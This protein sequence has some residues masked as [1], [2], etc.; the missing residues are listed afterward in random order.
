[1]PLPG[2]RASPAGPLQVLRRY[3]IVGALGVPEDR[4][5]PPAGAVVQ[6]L[7]AVDAARERLRIR[8]R[9]LR[10][11]RAE[12]VRDVAEALH[13]APDLALEETA[14]LQHRPARRRI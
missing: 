5:D 12:H 11:I 13:A 10:V 6:E 9:V 1:M 4:D 8:L 7:D 2:R 3:R 14:L